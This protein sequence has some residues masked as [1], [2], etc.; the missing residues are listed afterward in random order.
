MQVMAGLLVPQG[1][2]SYNKS[3][4]NKVPAQVEREIKDNI[5]YY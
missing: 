5:T 1:E 4:L 2:R 3:N